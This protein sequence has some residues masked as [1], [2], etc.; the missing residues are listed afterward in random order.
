MLLLAYPIAVYAD[1]TTSEF[2]NKPA[3]IV[4]EP[5]DPI[6]AVESTETIEPTEVNIIGDQTGPKEVII[7][8]DYTQGI[9]TDMAPMRPLGLRYNNITTNSISIVW[10]VNLGY[11][12]VESYNIYLNG[13]KIG[14]SN[15]SEY[16]ITNLLPGRTYE[17][18]VTA[19]NYYGESLESEPINVATKKLQGIAPTNLKLNNIT[20]NSAYISWEGEGLYSIYLNG[21]FVN[22]TNKNYYQLNNLEENNDYEIVIESNIDNSLYQTMQLRTGQAI[23]QEDLLKIIN[24]GFEYINIMSPYIAVIAGLIIAFAIASMLL[25]IFDGFL[26]GVR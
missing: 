14:N 9:T 17:I 8:E 5:T 3:E 25:G 16:T 13:S 22:T 15:V 21:D 23:P 7:T 19:I 24:I 11:D 6:E 2:I 18:T 10:D 4:E 12:E 1:V 20:E 26:S